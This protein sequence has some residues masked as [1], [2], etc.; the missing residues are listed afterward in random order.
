M[1]KY[2]LMLAGA[3]LLFSCSD[4]LDVSP[5]GLVI[6]KTV[7]EYGLLLVGGDS[8]PNSTDNSDVLHFSNDNF[9]LTS[10]EIGNTNNILNT[11]FN[12][13][14]WSENRYADPSVAN[15]AWNDGYRNIYVFN[16]IIEEIDGAKLAAGDTEES[17]KRIKAQA[18]YGRA[19]EYLFLVN[20]FSKQYKG[21]SAATDPGVPLVLKAD[22]TQT[23][24][25]RGTVAIVYDQILSD[26]DIAIKSLPQTTDVQTLPSIGTG[27]AFLARIYLYKN[28]YANAKKYAELALVA[29]SDL[30]DYTSSGFTNSNVSGKTAEQYSTHYMLLPGNGFLSD[31]AVALFSLTGENDARLKKLFRKDEVVQNGQVIGYRYKMGARDFNY[32]ASTSVSVPEMYLTLAECEARSGNQN[33]AILA[34]N[35]LRAKRITGNVALAAGDFVN[36]NAL[37]KFALAERRREMFYT[38]TRLFDLKREN[39]EP[40]FA[41]TTLHIVQ[42]SNPLSFN[43]EANSNKLVLPIPAQVLKFNPGMEQNK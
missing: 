35:T 3:V 40:A 14:S 26:M 30:S 10:G 27:Y 15:R 12:L 21:S 32:Q 11:S 23:L 41:K 13:Y 2:I 9:Y 1:K 4:Y 28:D 5:K 6:P 39:L 24:P 37:I 16:K 8:G 29:K 36:Q 42:G 22:V 43:A 34:L 7:E 33:A 17:R 20:T 18:Y 38:N 25:S 31:D 19:Y